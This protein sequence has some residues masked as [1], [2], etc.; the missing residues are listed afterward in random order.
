MIGIG[1][2]LLA[3]SVSAG[4]DGGG[5]MLALFLA[6]LLPFA[7]GLGVWALALTALSD[8]NVGEFPSQKLLSFQYV[9]G[10]ARHYPIAA[11]SLI[12]A[13]LSL[14]GFPLL[15]GF[16]P[17]LALWANLTQQY[18]ITSLAALLGSTGLLIAGLRTLA[19]LVRGSR[20]GKWHM[21]ESWGYMILL[22]LGVIILILGGIWPQIFF[23]PYADLAEI[24]VHLG[25]N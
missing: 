10:L 2:S 22:V 16:P 24:F 7:I 18:P 14:A 8:A 11:S 17:R 6:L 4:L 20:E 12:L 1:F 21:T 15:A 19:S 13:N 3:L 23:I 9:K 5:P 25:N